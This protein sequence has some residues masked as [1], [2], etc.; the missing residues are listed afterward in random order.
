MNYNL[1]TQK[2]G[3]LWYARGSDVN[4]WINAKDVNQSYGEAYYYNTTGYTIAA[5]KNVYY[6]A[7]LS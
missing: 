5:T 2:D 6:Q 3:N 1:V 7:Y 4:N